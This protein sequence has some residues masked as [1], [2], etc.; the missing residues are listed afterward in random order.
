MKAM[1]INK[2]E[3]FYKIVYQTE[4]R[5]TPSETVALMLIGAELFSGHQSL[6]IEETLKS[7][8]AD[9]ARTADDYYQ[10]YCELKSGVLS[11]N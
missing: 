9:T 11:S 10:M 7:L 3:L 5:L 6:R 2:L 4:S 1:A 8:K